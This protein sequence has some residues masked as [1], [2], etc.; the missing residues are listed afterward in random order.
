MNGIEVI[1]NI[2]DHINAYLWLGIPNIIKGFIVAL[3]FVLIFRKQIKAHPIVFY[4]YPTLYFLWEIITGIA[5]LSPDN[6]Y[7]KLGGDESLLLNIGW[8][9]DDLG[10][11]ATFGIALIIIVMFIGVVP[12]TTLVKNLYDI[13]TE[14]SIIGATIIVG[15]A[16]LQLDNIAS[17]NTYY[18]KDAGLLFSVFYILGPAT[19]ALILI[20]WITSFKS[21]RGKMKADSWKKL[22]TYTSIPLFI[23]MLM[24]GVVINLGWT[25]GHYTGFVDMWN[26]TMS[27]FY[28][29]ES[30][31]LGDGVS[32]AQD[33]FS[34]KVYLVLLVAYIVL[35][36]KKVRNAR[37]L[38]ANPLVENPAAE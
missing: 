32:F 4:A 3:V 31:S 22:Q 19:F 13:R 35:R 6:L 17:F 33:F 21:V 20:P 16:I 30:I 29:G 5:W 38:K 14:M 11:G 36:I 8:W 26:I 12:K 2:V 1:S 9:L 18:P 23:G 27:G 10:L 28:E 24:F 25:V 15:H 7:E 37:R 34:A